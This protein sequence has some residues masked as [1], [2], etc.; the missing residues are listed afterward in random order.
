MRRALSS[1]RRFRRDDG[2]AVAVE[3]ALVLPLLLTIVF[4]IIC[5]GQYF[6]VAHSLQQLAAEAAR[7]AVQEIEPQDRLALAEAVITTAG[8]RFV[9]L[10]P[11][12]IVRVVEV[13][14]GLDPAIAVSLEYDLTGTPLAIADSFLGLGLTRVTRSAYLVF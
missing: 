5:Y 6:A 8:P 12:R 7:A 14:T 1:L 2:G 10:D 3:F 11:D 9:F 4:G 13:G